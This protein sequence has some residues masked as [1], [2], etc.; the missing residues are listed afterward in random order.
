[1]VPAEGTADSRLTDPDDLVGTWCATGSSP[2]AASGICVALSGGELTLAVGGEAA[3]VSPAPPPDPWGS[4]SQLHATLPSGELWLSAGS[5]GRTL[6]GVFRAAR[7]GSPVAIRA[8]R[9]S[10]CCRRAAPAGIF[11]GPMSPMRGPSDGPLHSGCTSSELGAVSSPEV[12][13]LRHRQFAPVIA[14]APRNADVA[15][16]GDS[17]DNAVHSPPGPPLSSGQLLIHQALFS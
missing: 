1:M 4:C 14:P 8:R 3:V 13:P 16:G 17:A 12:A 5:G 6:C 7:G 11:T 15:E 2:F 10:P 9:G